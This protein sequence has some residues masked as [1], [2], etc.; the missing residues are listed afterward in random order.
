M[1]ANWREFWKGIRAMLL[2]L[3]AFAIG[4]LAIDTFF[5]PLPLSRYFAIFAVAIPL[6]LLI[7]TARLAY[8]L[9]YQAA[10]RARGAKPVTVVK[11][12]PGA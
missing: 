6:G 3:S 2:T 12:P 7:G 4:A 5:W 1:A 9:R 8:R 10:R 11:R